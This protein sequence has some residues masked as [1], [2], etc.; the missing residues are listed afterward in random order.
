MEEW[1]SITEA[2]RRLTDA[3]DV[4]ER[5]SLSRYL[6]QHAEALPT[7]SEG[8]TKLVEYG[9]LIRH[10]RENVRVVPQP[11]VQ[12]RSHFTG[13]QADGAARKAQADAELREMDLAERRKILTRTA[14]V[15]R[16]GRDA[17]ALMQSSYER[18][19]ET[20]ASD[21]SLKYGW[22]ERTAR[23]VLKKFT[24]IG[25]ENFN[26]IM[27]ERLDEMKSDGGVEEPEGDRSF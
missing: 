26:R 19:V 6:Q 12:R 10:R 18:A 22:D 27:L 15:D 5:S 23:T 1:I 25:M 20:V 11:I 4:I 21:V 13:T 24:R 16:A 2:A 7:R 17:I 9:A 8:R 14:E 3:G